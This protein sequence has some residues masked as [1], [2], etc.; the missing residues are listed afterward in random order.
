MEEII[1]AIKNCDD[2]HINDN[3]I[4]KAREELQELLSCTSWELNTFLKLFF[5]CD[6]R[7]TFKGEA[8]IEWDYA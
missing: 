6:V 2:D 7:I 5:E 3:K 8:P 4:A 1:I